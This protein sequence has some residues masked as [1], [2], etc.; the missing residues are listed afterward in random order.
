MTDE[1]SR[2]KKIYL[3]DVYDYTKRVEENF[4]YTSQRFMGKLS[5]KLRKKLHLTEES[6]KFNIIKPSLNV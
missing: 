6:K 3:T 5:H 1:P 4:S 2:S